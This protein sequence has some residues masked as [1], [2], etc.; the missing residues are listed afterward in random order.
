MAV[1]FLFTKM[2]VIFYQRCM[3]SR[4]D[5]E[6]MKMKEPILSKNLIGHA[7]CH[8][9]LVL[10][11]TGTGKTLNYI[12]P[13]LMQMDGSYIIADPKGELYAKT[14]HMFDKNGYD[15]RVLD[16]M[17]PEESMH[18]NPFVYIHE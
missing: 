1:L 2:R 17:R 5:I 3:Y 18:Y 8:N 12:I 6:R 10:G 13:N 15:I 7:N 4:K 11:R 9:T 16:F 14:R